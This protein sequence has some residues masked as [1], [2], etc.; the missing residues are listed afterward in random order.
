MIHCYNKVMAMSR[1]VESLQRV[2]K[3]TVVHLQYNGSISNYTQILDEIEFI[4]R[5]ECYADKIEIFFLNGSNF[6]SS[7]L[8]KLMV[9]GTVVHGGAE[10][11]C[12]DHKGNSVP[13]YYEGSGYVT[14]LSSMIVLGYPCNP[15][16]AFES[17]SWKLW[18][19]PIAT[20]STVDSNKTIPKM[21]ATSCGYTSRADPGRC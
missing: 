20:G 3:G 12:V 8:S 1:Y 9:N 2:M 17:L 14:G 16:K 6:S 11:G 5:V 4:E 18:S 13:F 19:E 15:F 7:A 21:L 10:W